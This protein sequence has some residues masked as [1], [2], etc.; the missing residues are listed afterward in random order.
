V[1][2]LRELVAP[3]VRRAAPAPV[4]SSMVYGDLF[5]ARS[6][7][8]MTITPQEALAVSTVQ[9]C[10]NLIARSLAS[11]PLVLYRRTP[12]GG[13]EPAEDHPLYTI[14]HDLANP[15]QTAYDVRQMLMA[16]T[17]LYGNG[18]ARIDW[19]E[20]GYPAALWPLSP[21]N[22][23]LYLDRDRSLIYRV[24]DTEYDV[25][26]VS[27]LPAWRV[28]HVRGLAVSGLLGMSPLRAAN[29]IGLAI[30][31]EEFGARF[32]AQGARPGYVLS[33]PATLSDSAYK[34]L[35]AS[36]NDN[37]SASHRVKIVEEGMRVEK[38]GVAPNEAQ[39]LET[40]ELQVREVC[41]IFGVSPGLIGAEQTQTY[42]SAEQDLIQFRELTLGPWSRNHRQAIQRDM[43]LGAE[44]SEYFVQYK[45]SALQA[46]DLKTRYEA[47][48]I[49]LLTG[50][51]TQNEVREMEDLNP[52]A[53]GDALW[54]PLNMTTT[55][56]SDAQPTQQDGTSAGRMAD[57]WLTDVRQRLAKRIA[58]DVRQA[59]ARAL[60]AG[61]REKFSEWGEEQLYEWRRAGE[62]MLA[63][64]RSALDDAEIIAAASVGDWVAAAYQ[65]AARELMNGDN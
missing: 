33:H 29:A 38:T 5:G 56:P 18:Y 1:S 57:A 45:L 49:A 53:G 19:S 2:V 43:L 40:R 46:T 48:Q 54:R 28:H 65:Q 31:T 16:S 7:A 50:F 52:V 58:N 41:R 11:V 30:A 22:V 42:A 25:G 3:L 26:R 13:R 44:R 32:F 15:L 4:Q 51:E 60:R 37:A 27:W 20:D 47:H 24:T 35:A 61:G 8:G 23:Q 63:P 34:R 62:E 10:V 55:A 39:F 6:A 12:D 21:E 36:W 59:G 14:L 17:L 64:L 9:A